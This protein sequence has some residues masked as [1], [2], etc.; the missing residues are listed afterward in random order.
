[1]RFAAIVFVV[2]CVLGA[3]PAES[4]ELSATLDPEQARV[5]EQVVLTVVVSGGVQNLP[6]PEIPD[7]KANF[8]FFPGGTSRSFSFINGRM[9][10]SVTLRYVLV[11]KHEG[12]FTIPPIKVAAKG[13]EVS[14]PPLKLVV[15]NAPPAP[16]PSTAPG[17]KGS[18]R[19]SDDLFVRA[20]VDK[21]SPSVYEQVTYKV[22]LYARLNLLDNPGFQPPTTQGF[23]REDLQPRDPAIETVKGKR[24]RVSEVDIAVFPTAPGKLTIGESVLECSVEVPVRSN[25]PFRM[26]G[27]VDGRRVVLRTDPV[28]LDVK[29]LPPGAP[30]SFHGAVG[31][32]A[33][34][35]SVDRTEVSQNEP[36][37]LTV[38]ITGEGHIRSFGDIEMAPL[39]DFRAY[40]SQGNEEISRQ[41]SRINGTLTKQFVLVPLSAGRKEIPAI[42]LSAFSP[43]TGRYQT[44]ATKAIPVTVKAGAAAAPGMSAGPRG[45][46][47]LVG[48]DIR[49]LETAVPSFTRRGGVWDSARAW[50][51][52]LPI[53]ALAYLGMWWWERQ[54]ERLG[55]D[56]GLRRRL[57]AARHA[58]AALKRARTIQGTERASKAAEA[59]R[60]Y[61]ADR[62]NLPTAGLLPEDIAA[63]MRGVEIDS[64]ALLAFLDRCDAAR[65]APGA[66]VGGD[67]D[68]LAEAA[69]WIDTLE[70]SR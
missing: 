20:F 35:A 59:V 62:F 61:V 40:P 4:L 34:T 60:G 49:F 54:R 5:G 31:E 64:A 18:T 22:K 9:S 7:L 14:T 63:S 38:K 45:D 29:P 55:R 69:R 13:E 24:Y 41:G 1:M 52:L 33:I 44:L 43:R 68:W 36:I 66:P 28:V 58:R 53:P 30:P 2:L 12:T 21:S 51:F 26:F 10:N 27:G 8:D 25:D 46:I 11:P 57:R 19:G 15:S 56:V 65:Y 48:R 37:T 32:Y 70:A 47:E 16:T 23:W 17:E 6:D 67:G 42:E 39:P 50:L 3:A